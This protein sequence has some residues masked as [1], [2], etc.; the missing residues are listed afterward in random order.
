MTSI[1]LSPSFISP[2]KM[3]SFIALGLSLLPFVAAQSNEIAAIKAHFASAGLVP[4]LLNQFEPTATLTVN[5]PGN[6]APRT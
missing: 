5:F 3:H 1:F 4:S 2:P 6:S